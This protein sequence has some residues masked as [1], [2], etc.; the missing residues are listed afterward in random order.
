MASNTHRNTTTA[1]LVGAILGLLC[2]WPQHPPASE[3]AAVVADR[4][5]R[6]IE[7]RYVEAVD[8]QQ[9]LRKGLDRVV[10]QLDRNSRFFPPA[11]AARFEQETGGIV[12]GIGIILTAA[13]EGGA[14]V[15]A[16]IP[17]GPADES[18]IRTQ[19]RITGID[20]DDCSDWTI[21]QLSMQIRGD[22]D[23]AVEIRV[24][25]DGTELDLSATR[26]QVQVP[27][28]TEIALFRPTQQ[29]AGGIGLIRLLQFQP[30]TSTEVRLAL[31]K[32]IA[33]GAEG[34]VLDLRN[35]GGG[36]F[37]E[38]IDV[39]SLFLEQGLT[40]VT[41][42][43]RSGPD[44]EKS[45]KVEQSGP[46]LEVPLVILIDGGSASASEIVASSLR[47]HRRAA[48]IGSLS[49]GKW[50]VQDLIPIRDGTE[51]SILK[52]TT[53]SF[54]APRGIRVSH[55]DSGH[56]SGLIP[57]L[58]LA[59]SP[60]VSLDLVR[61]WRGRSYERIEQPGAI[62]LLEDPHP[63]QKVDLLGNGDTALCAAIDRLRDPAA[64]RQWIADGAQ[65]ATVD[66]EPR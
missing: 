18:G 29:D 55:D 14:T 3:P 37:S 56:R 31:E 41:T 52:L 47:D 23:S 61:S 60:A 42:R 36:L 6:V 16:V 5:I 59:T 4:V 43:G 21:E 66:Q 19:D 45:V 25:R 11:E 40:V 15:L 20:G 65:D 2:G 48:L 17:G 49:F 13:A 53:Q 12:F 39:V 34:V 58:E 30:D 10:Q 22:L 1:L 57:D 38:A 64:L 54:H 46:F 51:T 63:D 50:S 35:N 7:A 32:L 26:G 33:A 27:S 9:L 44:S 8:G 28:V 24:E 62:T